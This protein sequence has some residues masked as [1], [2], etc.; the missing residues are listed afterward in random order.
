MLIYSTDTEKVCMICFIFRTFADSKSHEVSQRASKLTTG[1]Y[2]CMTSLSLGTTNGYVML[3]RINK[4]M[5]EVYV[6]ILYI[7]HKVQLHNLT[8]QH[9]RTTVFSQKISLFKI[10]NLVTNQ[11]NSQLAK[12]RYLIMLDLY[13]SDNYCKC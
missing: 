13:T 7:S 12:K 9:V 1:T 4:G 11:Y 3:Q 10:D 6:K 5:R 8:L 2:I